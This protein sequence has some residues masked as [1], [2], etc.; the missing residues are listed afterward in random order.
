[1]RPPTTTPERPARPGRPARC[2]PACAAGVWLIVGLLAAASLTGCNTT[3]EPESASEAVEWVFDKD[4]ADKRRKGVNYLSS[5][6]YG[7]EAEY[8]DAYRLRAR[9]TDP[10]VRATSAVALGLHGTV[11]DAEQLAV[12]LRDEEA[13]VR[14]HAA[15]ALRKVHNPE[16]VPALLERLS[17]DVEDD[18]DVSAAAAAALGQY[19]DR[20][21]FS[22]LVQAMEQPSYHVVTAAHRSLVQLTGHDAGLDSRD[23]ADW[24]ATN[25]EPFKDQQPYTY[26]AYQRTRSWFDEYVTFWNNDD[27]RRTPRGL[28]EISGG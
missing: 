13:L 25:A 7:G 21:V 1:M 15:D 27:G 5:K 24:A 22:R 23:W 18:P 9:D 10:G 20:V 19:P 8:V 16:A 12:M 14:W 11:R 26:Q 28:P 6:S 3:L 17:P 2:G 4:N